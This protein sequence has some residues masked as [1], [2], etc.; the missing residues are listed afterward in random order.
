MAWRQ[1]SSLPEDLKQDAIRVR[2]AM[3]EIMEAGANAE[4]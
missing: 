2:D 4:W 1:G 3:T